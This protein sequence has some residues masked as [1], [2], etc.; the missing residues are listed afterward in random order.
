MRNLRAPARVLAV[1]AVGGAALAMSGCVS[2]DSVGGAQL[3][4]VGT[5]LIA[6]NA[7]QSGSTGCLNNDVVNADLAGSTGTGQ[8]LVAYRIPSSVTPAATVRGD[9]PAV[10]FAASPTYAAELERLSPAGPGRQWVGYISSPIDIAAADKNITLTGGFTLGQGADGSPFP[11]P[12]RYRASIGTRSVDGTYPADRPVVCGADVN[13]TG[14]GV[15]VCLDSP[16]LAAV[17]GPDMI[18]GTRDLGILTGASGTGQAGTTVTVPFT[19]PYSGAA[20]PTL[21]FALSAATTVPGGT[22]TVTPGSLI[23]AADS[24][25]PVSVAVAVPAGT[26][27]GNY[28][29]TLTARLGAGYLAQTRVRTGTLVVAPAPVTPPTAVAALRLSG[30]LP[31]RLT[32]LAARTKGVR[33]TVRSNRSGRAVVRL[34]QRRRILLARTVRLRNGAT[35]VVLRSR[36]VVAGAYRVTVRFTATGRI[37][38]LRGTLRAG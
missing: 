30:S 19:A 9:T 14:P 15:T 3:D 31:G 2:L 10:T 38:T 37:A 33:V 16:Q 20:D 1:A 36:K 35:T 6:G 34:V 29:V 26:A 4:G 11:G 32:F 8:L 25:N 17:N 12:L 24:T 21:N 22:V 28:D 5:V 23:P 27:P 18:L 7:C 13:T